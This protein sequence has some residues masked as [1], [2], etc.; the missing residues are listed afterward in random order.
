[1]RRPTHRPRHALA[2]T[3]S[4]GRCHIPDQFLGGRYGQNTAT[5]ADLVWTLTRESPDLTRLDFRERSAGTFSADPSTISGAWEEHP[6]SGWERDFA[7]AYR[8][9]CW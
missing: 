8:R 5:L 7:L 4:R 3:R 9:A 1:V 6:C 2:S